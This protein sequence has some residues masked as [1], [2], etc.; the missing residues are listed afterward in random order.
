MYWLIIYTV[1]KALLLVQLGVV[2]PNTLGIRTPPL[3]AQIALDIWSLQDGVV[4]FK[5]GVI[6]AGFPELS[7]GL[8]ECILRAI[9][10]LRKM[11]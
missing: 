6:C 3:A 11:S 1:A 2:P 7:H 4:K 9:Q 10:T 5:D 8:G